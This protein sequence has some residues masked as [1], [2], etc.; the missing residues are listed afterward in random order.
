MVTIK[1]LMIEMTIVFIVRFKLIATFFFVSCIKYTNGINSPIKNKIPKHS[2]SLVNYFIIPH[3][4]YNKKLKLDI[5]LYV[6][7]TF[8]NHT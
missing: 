6:K 1:T 2:P 3:L 4:F 5:L 8:F 7:V